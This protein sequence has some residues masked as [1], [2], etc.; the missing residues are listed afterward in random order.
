MS[1]KKNYMESQH[2]SD[3]VLKELVFQRDTA[4]TEEE[5]TKTAKSFQSK[6]LFGR[7]SPLEQMQGTELLEIN[8]LMC[9]F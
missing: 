3:A 8:F 4:R 2:L 6:D 7:I 5:Q 9:I 1:K